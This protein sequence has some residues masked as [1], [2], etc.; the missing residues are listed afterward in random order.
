VIAVPC[1]WIKQPQV[2]PLNNYFFSLLFLFDE[3]IAEILAGIVLGPTVLG[4]IPGFS[5]T[6]FPPLCMKLKRFN[7][8]I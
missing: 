3:V 6:L 4:N 7:N 5:E 1:K 2:L 8:D